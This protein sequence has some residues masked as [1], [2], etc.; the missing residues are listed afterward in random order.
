MAQVCD[1]CLAKG[2]LRN[3]KIGEKTYDLCI[4]CSNRVIDWINEGNKK[5][6]LLGNLFK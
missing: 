5:K 4:E 2:S 1:R 3:V 6:G